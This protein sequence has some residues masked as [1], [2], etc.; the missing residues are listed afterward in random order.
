MLV[1]ESMQRWEYRIEP[2]MPLEQLNAF[3]AEGW[4]LVERKCSGLD[5]FVFR[6]PT[7]SFV[8]RVTMEQRA[9]VYESLGLDPETGL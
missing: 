4:E 5:S 9:R 2:A 3:G 1:V 7:Q 8:E 6:R